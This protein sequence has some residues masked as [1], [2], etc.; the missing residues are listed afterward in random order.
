M[1]QRSGKLRP[2]CSLAC[3]EG[4]QMKAVDVPHEHRGFWRVEQEW[5]NAIR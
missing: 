5:V 3:A 1:Q 2:W 4:G